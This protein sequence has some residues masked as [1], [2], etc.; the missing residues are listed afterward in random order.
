MSPWQRTTIKGAECALVPTDLAVAYFRQ[1]SP[2]EW[3]HYQTSCCMCPH[4]MEDKRNDWFV[5]EAI[6]QT[7]NVAPCVIP[8]DPD[9]VFVP[10]HVAALLKLEE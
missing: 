2:P 7:G 10:V 1:E 3:S 8:N 9:H 6:R 4:I 5:C